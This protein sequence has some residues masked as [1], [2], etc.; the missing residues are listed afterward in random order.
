MNRR[1]DS[2]APSCRVALVGFVQVAAIAS[3]A[4]VAL[5][6]SASAQG[7]SLTPA[8]DAITRFRVA[9]PQVATD[10]LKMRLRMT[11]LP[12]KQTVDAW[13]QGVPLATTKA[14][15][16]YWRDRYDWR[17]F[18]RPDQRL[19]AVPHRDRRTWHPLHPCAVS[20]EAGRST[21]R[22]AASASTCFRPEQPL[23]PSLQGL[24][25]SPE[26][27]KALVAG[28]TAQTPLGRI[29]QPEETASVALFLASE[30]SSFMTG[31]EVFVDGGMAQV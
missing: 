9:V 18:E 8:S 12:D 21:S 17:R 31:A 20:R 1:E 26:Q 3:V 22:T 14:L 19:S 6:S 10:D 28:L 23:T 7:P 16:S 27:E 5:G 15:I 13:S 29:G 24:A 11:R 4:N 2:I 30:D 25:N